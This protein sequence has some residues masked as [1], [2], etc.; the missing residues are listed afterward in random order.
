MADY[1]LVYIPRDLWTRPETLHLT[2]ILGN[3]AYAVSLQVRAWIFAQA[4]V[5]HGTC[6]VPHITPELLDAELKQ[7]GS[8]TALEQAGIVTFDD[9][10]ATFHGHFQDM[11]LWRYRRQAKR[12]R[13]H[14]RR[15]ERREHDRQ[16]EEVSVS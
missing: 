15:R 12:R 14:A 6:T 1:K 11:M 3:K 5:I 9:H 13:Y 16:K 8:V 10:G 4:A 2:Q 7:D